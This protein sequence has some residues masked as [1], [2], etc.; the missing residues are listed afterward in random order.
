MAWCSFASALLAAFLQA[1]HWHWCSGFFFVLFM[2]CNST[3]NLAV[4][5]LFRKHTTNPKSY[6][7]AATKGEPCL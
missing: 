6:F 4:S 7:S 2:T 5:D 3:V 1:K